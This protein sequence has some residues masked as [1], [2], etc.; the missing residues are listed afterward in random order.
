MQIEFPEKLKFLF[1]PHPYKVLYGG[2]GGIKSWSVAQALLIEGT[3]KPL[4]VLC[5]RETQKSIAES[6]HHLLELQ[7]GR[8]GLQDFYD[9]EKAHI[10]GKNGTEFFFSGLRDAQNLKSYESVDRVW[11]EE[12]ALISKHSFDILLPTLRKPGCEVVLTFNPSLDTDECWKRF[13]LDP[14]PGAV[15][16][17][18]SWRDNKWLTPEFKAQIDRCRETDPDGYLNIFEGHCLQVLDGAIYASE[19]RALTQRGAITRVPYDPALPVHTFWDL[20][21]SDCTSI[22]FVQAAAF[23]FRFIDFLQDRN[24]ALPYYLQELQKRGYVYGFHHLPHDGKRRDL[25]TGKSI[26]H[27]MTEAGFKVKIVPDI[28]FANGLN[29]ARNL[30]VRAYI[31][32]ERCADGLNCLRRYCWRVDPVTRVYSKE[33]VHNDYSHG[34]DAWRMAG[35]GLTEPQRQ[36]EEKRRQHAARPSVWS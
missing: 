13:V 26:E 32:E 16:V 33:P 10:Y 23:E 5:A 24:R 2:R 8:L 15:A 35:V 4:R 20:G 31:D 27:H 9:V 21:I 22:W 6:V 12:S 34:A 19:M 29:A 14:P 28:G 11:L 3:Q 18:T 25:G 36:K 30:F 1:E 17:K 7:I